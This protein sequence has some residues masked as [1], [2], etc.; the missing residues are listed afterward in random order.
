MLDLST[1]VLI[2]RILTLLIAFTT[3]EY[4]HGRIA[5]LYGDDTPRLAGRLTLNPLSHLDPIG[6][7]MLLLFGFGWA[8][9]VPIN[10]DVIRRKSKSGVMVVSLAGP[11]SNFLLAVLGA[12]PCAFWGFLLLPA[13]PRTFSPR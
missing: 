4:A 13:V 3:H 5:E 2:S 8:K 1:S 7:L 9:P 10:P 11:F 12:I 6:S